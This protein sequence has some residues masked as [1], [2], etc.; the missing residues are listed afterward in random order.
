MTTK[1]SPRAPTPM[2]F[3]TSPG[4]YEPENR[5]FTMVPYLEPVLKYSPWT[6]PP[7]YPLPRG[8]FRDHD[9]P[10]RLTC[11]TTPRAELPSPTDEIDS[12]DQS[13]Q[14]M[15]RLRVFAFRLF[16][17]RPCFPGN[18]HVWRAEKVT[19]ATDLINLMSA[20]AAAVGFLTEHND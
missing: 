18:A 10:P 2:Q 14:P 4:F 5:T 11:A 20:L 15:R 6:P 17:N 13:I 1:C 19:A 7:C 3:V 8:K 12:I 9:K 16:G